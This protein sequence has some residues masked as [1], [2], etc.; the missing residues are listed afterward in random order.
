MVIR[1]L[2]SMSIYTPKTRINFNVRQLIPPTGP[3][4]NITITATSLQPAFWAADFR[5]YTD[6]IIIIIIIR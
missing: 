4:S 1:Q 5:A 3:P 6:I 2:D